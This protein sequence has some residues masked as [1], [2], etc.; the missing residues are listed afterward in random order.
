MAPELLETG[1]LTPKADV[2]SFGIILWEMLTR[3]Q[4]YDGCSVF[5]VLERVRLNKRPEIPP[6]C[7]TELAK[8]VQQCW[9]PVPSKRPPFKDILTQ[10]EDMTFPSEWQD[11]FR[12]AGVPPEALEDV[13]STRTLISL[14]TNSLDTANAKSLIEDIK[15]KRSFGTYPEPE[16][17]SSKVSQRSPSPNQSDYTNRSAEIRPTSANRKSQDVLNE[18]LQSRDLSPR[19][20][21]SVRSPR[22]HFAQMNSESHRKPVEPLVIPTGREDSS[23]GTPKSLRS[24]RSSPDTNPFKSSPD[25]ARSLRNSQDTWRSSQV[26]QDGMENVRNSKT[27][28]SQRSIR[29]STETDKY[30]QNQISVRKSFT[31][32]CTDVKHSY[33]VKNPVVSSSPRKEIN[34][35]QPN[36]NNNSRDMSTNSTTSINSGTGQTDSRTGVMQG[37]RNSDSL[38]FSKKSG[39]LRKSL[40]SDIRNSSDVEIKGKSS[41]DLRQNLLSEVRNSKNVLRKSVQNVTQKSND[42]VDICAQASVQVTPRSGRDAKEF[43]RQVINTGKSLR[44]SKQDSPPSVSSIMEVDPRGAVIDQSKSPASTQLQ[45][46]DYWEYQSGQPQYITGH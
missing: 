43:Q 44:K 29:N 26:F 38:E 28:E 19:K 12:E 42:K 22:E 20:I 14:V 11:L 33:D 35:P 2:Y 25:T 13:H 16:E 21:N 40:M 23:Q 10:L 37:F 39:D 9:A 45:K 7:P 8:F 4:P 15:L 34:S 6:S 46:K 32:S 30:H 31:A 17:G 36:C 5:Q 27:A 1:E 41:V 3:K 18:V 24:S